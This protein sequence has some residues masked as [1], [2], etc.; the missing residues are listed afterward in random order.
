M[1]VGFKVAED[2]RLRGCQ[3]QKID[4]NRDLKVA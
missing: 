1:A 3:W 2:D 4:M